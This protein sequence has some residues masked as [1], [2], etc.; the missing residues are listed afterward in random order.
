MD[1]KQVLEQEIQR[2]F[3]D[4]IQL[5]NGAQF[6]LQLEETRKDFEGDF[7][8]VVFP[9]VSLFKMK[10]EE[11]GQTVGNWLIENSNFFNSFNVVK[12]FLN[13]SINDDY[14]IQFL[15]EFSDLT[16]HLSFP[17]TGKTIMV[18]FSSPNTNKPLHLGHVRNML[19][20]N[21]IANILSTTGNHVIRTQIINDRGIAICKSM[22]AW[23]LFGHNS[24]PESDNIKGDHFVGKYYVLFETRFQEEYALWQS[25]LEA[26]ALQHQ[27]EQESKSFFK[28]FKNEYFNKYSTLGKQAKEMLLKWEQNDPDTLDL[29]KTMNGWVYEGFEKTYKDYGITFDSIYYESNTYLLGKEIIEKGL[30]EEY[31]YQKSDNSVW[32]DLESVGLDQKVLL[33]SDGTS[34]YIT[35]DIGTAELRNKDYHPNSMIYV[36]ADEQNYHFQVLFEI[37]K[38]MNVPY[39]EGLHHLSYGMVELPEGRMKSR[40]GTVVDA[41]DLLLEVITEAENISNERGEL[42]TLTES[43]KNEIIRK[44]GIGALKYFMLKVQPKRKMVFDPKESVDMQ[45]NTGPYIQNAY[46]RIQSIKRKYSEKISNF[47]SNLIVLNESERELIKSLSQYRRSIIKASTDLD[48]SEIAAYCYSLAKTFHKFYHDCPILSAESSN[49]QYFR[50]QLAT[51]TANTLEHG[52]SLLGIEM[53]EKM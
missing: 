7:T 27:S 8:L 17:S 11:I 34:V 49:T 4:K 53:P 37:L 13:L 21:S 10:P 22:V 33:R 25:T 14:W 1:I 44:I 46:V 26:L 6:H 50:I 43:S 45:G 32:V 16:N 36:V 18:E 47:D 23:K 29:W 30:E 5:E 24:T 48:P 9:L 20:G 12:G 35:Q 52:M 28:Q 38:L 2:I 15:H 39:A 42:E 51:L 31:F 19:L 40:E 41:D 3:N